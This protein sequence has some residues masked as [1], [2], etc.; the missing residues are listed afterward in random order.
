MKEA[1]GSL[2]TKLR[3][4]ALRVGQR[5]RCKITWIVNPSHFYINM[6]DS[7]P[8]FE[9]LMGKLQVQASSSSPD[10]KTSRGSVVAAKWSDGC[11]YRGQVVKAGNQGSG[12]AI[13][14]FFVDFGNTEKVDRD[15]IVGLPFEFGQLE[16]QAMG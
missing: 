4:G 2:A 5:G 14:I 7:G 10:V 3:H 8:Q 11:W 13:E 16:T 9:T 12:G 6:I 15:Q 1:A